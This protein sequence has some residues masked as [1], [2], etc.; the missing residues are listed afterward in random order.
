MILQKSIYSD[1]TQ[2]SSNIIV[3]AGKTLANHQLFF[4]FGS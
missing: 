3:K 4:I 1:L 2:L